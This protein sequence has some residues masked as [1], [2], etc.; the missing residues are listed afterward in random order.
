MCVFDGNCK[1]GLYCADTGFVT[2]ACRPRK[3][4]GE[5]CR[6]ANHCQSFICKA[7]KCAEA[8]PENAYCLAALQ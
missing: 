1:D 4:N 3:A 5:E 6:A 8:T 2:G 7:S